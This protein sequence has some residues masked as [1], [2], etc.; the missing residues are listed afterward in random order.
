MAYG[1][2]DAADLILVDLATKMPA[3]LV[4]YANATS[5]EWTAESVYANKKVLVRF[6]GMTLVKVL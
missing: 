5:S 1:M 3:L 6:V 2:K 4:D